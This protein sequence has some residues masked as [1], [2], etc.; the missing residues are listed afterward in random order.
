MER[1]QPYIPA[2]A[3]EEDESWHQRCLR[4]AGTWWERQDP[5]E[6]AACCSIWAR[7]FDHCSAVWA[8][9]S[10]SLGKGAPV[11]SQGPG[12][13]PSAG[14]SA[15]RKQVTIPPFDFLVWKTRSLLLGPVD[16]EATSFSVGGCGDSV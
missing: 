5:G 12:S 7:V 10:V 3:Q 2:S 15:Y 14:D 6:D 11:R 4:A 8:P 16:T 13:D 9:W 1:S